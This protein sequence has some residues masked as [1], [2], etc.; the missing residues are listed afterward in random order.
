M[1]RNM[2]E[3]GR[4]LE[5]PS[6][7][8]V[9][10]VV[11]YN[12]NPVAVAPNQN[13]VRKGFARDDLFTVVMEQF[14]TD[15]AAYADILLPATTFLEHSDLYYSYGHYYLQLA[16]PALPAPG[17]CRTNVDVFRH[18]AKAL[19]FADACFDDS[20][21]EMM[22]QALDSGHPALAGI[23]LEALELRKSIRLNVSAA[24]EPFLPHAS[25]GFGTP[26][27]HCEFHPELLEYT[28]PVESRNGDAS[29]RTLYPLELISAKTDSGMNS[30]F[31]HR[32]DFD[33]ECQVLRIHPD[34][35]AV[36]GIAEG[37]EVR[38]S[39]GRGS[40]LLRAS[41]SED[42][43]PGLVSATAVRWSSRAIDRAGINVLT[44]DVLNDMGGGPS[45]F[46]CLVEVLK[47]Q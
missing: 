31:G 24:G 1:L 13:R 21:D 39:N 10:A 32:S 15:T 27:G 2:S 30:T 7:D 36:R 18:L 22:R 6:A 16:R 3:I 28:A 23:T 9:H 19:G 17:E 11:V 38:V 40:L 47:Q 35:A 14:V 12:S 4:I 25:G 26:S 20:E 41:I 29:R 33:A 34:D 5:M 42:V 8:P 46:S 37:D 44:T 45:F 43:K